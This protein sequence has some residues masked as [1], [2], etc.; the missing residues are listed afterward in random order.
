MRNGVFVRK[1]YALAV[2]AA[3][4]LGLTAVP[5]PSQAAPVSNYLY[6][7]ATGATFVRVLDRTVQSD[8]TSRSAIGGV[9]SSSDSRRLANVNAQ[10]IITAGAVL[11]AL[12]CY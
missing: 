9:E 12:A 4:T 6:S 5:A 8:L 1:I 10:G 7:A 2:F 11:G 3:M